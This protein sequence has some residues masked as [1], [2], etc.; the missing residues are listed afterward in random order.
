MTE[1]KNLHHTSTPMLERFLDPQSQPDLAI[2]LPF[3]YYPLPLD[4]QS[5][6]LAIVALEEDIDC[7]QEHK[8]DHDHDEEEEEEE[9]MEN[10]ERGGKFAVGNE[11]VKEGKIRGLVPVR[12]KL[13]YG[14]GAGEELDTMSIFAVPPSPSSIIA[15]PPS[16][17]SSFAAAA[18]SSS[19]SSAA[20]AA[21]GDEGPRRRSFP[22]KKRVRKGEVEFVAFSRRKVDKRVDAPREKLAH[23][24]DGVPLQTYSC[25][26]RCVVKLEALRASPLLNRLLAPYLDETTTETTTTTSTTTTTTST[27]TTEKKKKCRLRALVWRMNRPL[28]VH[29]LCLVIDA[30]VTKSTLMVEYR[31]SLEIAGVVHFLG[32]RNILRV[33]QP[34][35]DLNSGNFVMA[36]SIAH[37]Y[38]MEWLLDWCYRWF[39]VNV[40]ETGLWSRMMIAYNSTRNSPK[41]DATDNNNNG[42]A[43]S[44][45]APVTPVAVREIGPFFNT[46]QQRDYRFPIRSFLPLY[47]KTMLAI[48]NFAR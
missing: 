32:V 45:P 44:T 30:M 36:C 15:I 33:N 20:V 7:K 13:V 3:S 31:D 29:A 17:S 9:E 10:E 40:I 37:E 23:E 16:P 2:L 22:L 38:R 1:V 11:E 14:G 28:A 46:L 39:L 43:S 35:V 24:T 19:P 34:T 5:E 27:T 26:R 21:Q 6:Q 8:D 18:S 42:A 4:E 47:S 12:P 48:A 41:N 25:E